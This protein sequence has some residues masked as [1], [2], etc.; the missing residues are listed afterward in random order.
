MKKLRNFKI[1]NACSNCSER[2]SCQ[3]KERIEGDEKN[4][5]LNCDYYERD[6]DALSCDD[7][8]IKDNCPG[9]L[10]QAAT[11][12]EFVLDYHHTCYDCA[13]QDTCKGFKEDG[14][15]CDKFIEARYCLTDK[16]CFMLAC[17]SVLG[18]WC[19]SNELI[20]PLFEDYKHNM[21]ISGLISEGDCKVIEVIKDVFK[22]IKRI[23]NGKGRKN[24]YDIFMELA[25]RNEYAELFEN[26]N[27]KTEV[28]STFLKIM[29]EQ[30]LIK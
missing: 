6:D 2:F 13:M 30:D 25:N 9:Y 3:L 11:C 23:F 8:K 19:F 17:A 5:R 16:G 22:D 18:E 12:T 7:C 24:S 21:Y 29:K 28:Y 15:I 26:D 27:Q 14:D 1:E 4:P 10:P 20:N